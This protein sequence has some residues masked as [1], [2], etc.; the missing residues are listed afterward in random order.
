MSCSAPP[1]HIPPGILVNPSRDTQRDRPA[2]T[3]PRQHHV[4]N[5]IQCGT[6]HTIRHHHLC[7][8]IF[9]RASTATMRCAAFD[10]EV[11]Q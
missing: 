4:V 3:A 7:Q 10:E 11:M 9:S 1:V 2:R 5:R 6:A 8:R